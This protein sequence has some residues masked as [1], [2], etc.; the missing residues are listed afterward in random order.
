MRLPAPPTNVR[1][2]TLNRSPPTYFDKSVRLKVSPNSAVGT[3]FPQGLFT[4]LDIFYGWAF[5]AS[6]G[7]PHFESE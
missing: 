4:R 2:P 3:Q 5:D 6:V 1:R 7:I